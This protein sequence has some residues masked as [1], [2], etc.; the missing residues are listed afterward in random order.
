MFPGE[1]TLYGSKRSYF[2]AKIENILKFQGLPYSLVE[3]MPH[4]GSAIETRTG[5]GAIPALVTPEDWPLAD[6]TPNA[7]CS[8]S[9]IAPIHPC[10][11][12][13]QTS[14]TSSPRSLWLTKRNQPPGATL[15][16]HSWMSCLERVKTKLRNQ[17]I[18][19]IQRPRSP[20]RKRMH[21]G[22]ST[23]CLTNS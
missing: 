2:T 10:R 5:S 17:R 13:T 8:V 7:P 22:S 12:K 6:S 21:A 4:D 16:A 11:K 23:T 3:K 1:Y 9:K 15:R 19:N 18:P 20:A 14:A